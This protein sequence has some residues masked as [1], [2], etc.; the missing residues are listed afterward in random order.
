MSEVWAAAITIIT[1]LA[2]GFGFLWREINRRFIEVGARFDRIEDRLAH[3]DDVLR[4]HAERLTA[5]EQRSA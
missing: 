4:E 1:L 2:A 3:I 5:L